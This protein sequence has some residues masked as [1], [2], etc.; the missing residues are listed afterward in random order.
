MIYGREEK[1]DLADINRDG[2]IDV[3]DASMIIDMVYGRY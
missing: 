3:F 1:K 2:T